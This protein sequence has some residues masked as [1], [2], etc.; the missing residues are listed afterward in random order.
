MKETLSVKV[1][2]IHKF[3]GAGAMRAFVDMNINDEILIRG[4]KVVEGKNGL[5]VSMPQEK[6]KDNKWYPVV[7]CLSPQTTRDITDLILEAYK[8]E[9]K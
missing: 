7:R 8:S 4:L 1:A 2:R 9:S 5:F 3:S 6:G